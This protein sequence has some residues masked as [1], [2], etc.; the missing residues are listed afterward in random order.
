MKKFNINS[1]IKI[2]LVC[3]AIAS[4]FWPTQDS[5]RTAALVGAAFFAFIF[6]D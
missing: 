6:L 4:A 1:I 3:A 2:L 5:E